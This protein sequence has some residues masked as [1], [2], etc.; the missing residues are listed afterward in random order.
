[1]RFFKAIHVITQPLHMDQ[2]HGVVNGRSHASRR[3]V[4]AQLHNAFF[5]CALQEGIVERFIAQEESHVHALAV[6]TVNFVE[7]QPAVV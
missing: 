7:K 4:T 2:R 1:M 6:C 3:T 5:F